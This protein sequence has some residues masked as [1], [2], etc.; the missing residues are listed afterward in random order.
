MFSIGTLD[1]VLYCAQQLGIM[2]AVGAE[3]TVLVAYI[4]SMRDGIIDPSE[5]HFARI[6]HRALIVGIS[7]IV[8]SGI[9][10]T[11]VHSSIGESAI[12]YEPVFLFK[13]ALILAVTCI[14]LWQRKKAFSH[15]LI[16]GLVGA[17]WFS[18]FLVHIFAPLISWV[19]LLT[20]YVAIL[21]LFSIFWVFLVKSTRSK[22]RAGPAILKVYPQMQAAGVPEQYMSQI[23]APAPVKQTPTPIPIPQQ[24]ITPVQEPVMIQVKQIKS[25]SIP[26]P[27]AQP[28]VAAPVPVPVAPTVTI[29]VA[30]EP[31]PPVQTIE[32]PILEDTS[33]HDPHNSPWLPAIHVMPKSRAELDSNAHVRPLAAINQTA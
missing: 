17:T 6:V 32:A 13:W 10:I 26:I 2:L 21:V 28:V 4:L 20:I 18:L 11:V 19:N 9:I 25:T 1:L 29:S 3:T 33:H 8:V 22:L 5:A 31:A 15:Y 12:I 27:S 30:V 14:Y 7:C 23:V 24:P 16:E